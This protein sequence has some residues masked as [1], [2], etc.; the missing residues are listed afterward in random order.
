MT[1]LRLTLLALATALL[2]AGCLER[3]ETITV[4]P[5]GG[6]DMEV[7]YT[8]ESHSELYLGDAV[9]TL[10]QG[11]IVEESVD[12]DEEGKE[13]FTLR[14]LASFPPDSPLPASYASRRDPAP[15]Q[16]L[17]FPTTVT[18]TEDEHGLRYDF[19]R[20]Y[21]PRPWA[22][23]AAPEERLKDGVE[24]TLNGR[25]IQELSESERLQVLEAAVQGE[26]LKQRTF[27]RLAFLDVAPDAPQEAWLAMYEAMAEPARSLD[28][29]RIAEMMSRELTPEDEEA[30]DATG[31][32]LDA[33]TLAAAQRAMREVGLGKTMANEIIE[34]FDYHR[35]YHEITSDLGDDAFEITVV[36]PGRIVGHNGDDRSG[37]RVTWKFGG[38]YV[39]DRDIELM[40][41]SRVP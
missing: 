19:R 20:I 3:K 18:V 22:F 33:E 29:L 31:E 16:S 11:W 27:A 6:V 23:L 30:L 34:R 28:L 24:K 5:D 17:Q 38:D 10:D 8:S 9:P 14:A 4:R 21:R 40:V 26:V 41:T 15:E 2:L 36:M 35:R 13:T 37:S 12:V 1:R 39:R 7:V 32:R 25:E